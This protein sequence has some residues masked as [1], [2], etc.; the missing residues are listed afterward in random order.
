MEDI[1]RQLGLRSLPGWILI[2]LGIVD[3]LEK[4][5]FLSEHLSFLTEP[6]GRSTLILLGLAY[7]FHPALCR[8]E[9]R[10]TTAGNSNFVS[11]YSFK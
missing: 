5:T 9:T 4:A 11:Q 7:F 3:V 1:V 6:W 2:F 10:E 8:Q